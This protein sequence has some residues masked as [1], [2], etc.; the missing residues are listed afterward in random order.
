MTLPL[1]VLIPRLLP[2]C[3]AAVKSLR[4]LPATV[5]QYTNLMSSEALLLLDYIACAHVKTLPFPFERLSTLYFPILICSQKLS[6]NSQPTTRP[7]SNATPLLKDYT[8]KKQMAGVLYF[9]V[10]NVLYQIYEQIILL[11]VTVKLKTKRT[12]KAHSSSF[13]TTTVWTS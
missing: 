12:G 10:G 11:L 4:T 13:H 2:A 6:A 9:S 3:F 7:L 8:Y 1:V 5:K